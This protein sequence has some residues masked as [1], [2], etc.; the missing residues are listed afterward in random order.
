MNIYKEV[1]NIII[2]LFNL[3]NFIYFHKQY[4][5]S[6]LNYSKLSKYQYKM[7]T[8]LSYFYNIEPLLTRNSLIENYEKYIIKNNN[9]KD[10]FNNHKY[11]YNSL[12][13]ANQLN[14][15]MNTL[16]KY[17]INVL[18]YI[19]TI[20][21]HSTKSLYTYILKLNNTNK[22][23]KIINNV[24]YKKIIDNFLQY[25]YNNKIFDEKYK[26]FVEYILNILKLKLV[27]KDNY[28]LFEIIQ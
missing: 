5:I 16:D 19:R 2:I 10:F 15:E 14:N 28:F 17:N 4:E 7:N 1:L 18:K 20:K 27:I 23:K 21:F 9:N 22:L 13:F 3:N 11:F 12:R 26:Q 6:K 25:N 8:Y 24:Q